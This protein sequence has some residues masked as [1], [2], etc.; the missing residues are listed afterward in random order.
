VYI[1]GYVY[2]GYAASDSGTATAS[3]NI[4]CTTKSHV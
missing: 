2:G 3:E 1:S 4:V